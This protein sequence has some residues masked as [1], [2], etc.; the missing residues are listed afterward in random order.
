MQNNL[1]EIEAVGHQAIGNVRFITGEYES[2]ISNYSKSLAAAKK[3]NDRKLIVVALNNLSNSYDRKYQQLIS[4]A[5]SAEELG[6]T[7]AN[8][9]EQSSSMAVKARNY[10]I[11]AVKESRF[12][13]SLFSVEAILQLVKLAKVYSEKGIVEPTLVDDHLR[14]A[15][16]I[17]SNL[18]SSQRKARALIDMARLE[19]DSVSTLNYALEVAESIGDLPTQSMALGYLGA[20]YERIRDYDKALQ[21]THRAQQVAG[22]IRAADLLYRWDWQAGRIYR[23]LGRDKDAVRAYQQ[24]IASLQLIRSDLATKSEELQI[25]FQ[26]EVEPVYRQLIE[27]LLA[28]NHSER[29]IRQALE[30]KDLLQLSELENYFG[31]DCIIVRADETEVSSS[32]TERDKTTVVNTIILEQN[33]YLILQLPNGGVKSFTLPVSARQ[34]NQMVEQW[35]YDLENQENESYLTLSRELYQLLFKTIKS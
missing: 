26:L 31:D 9:L 18:P 16:E 5:E 25:D 7:E 30:V 10:A 27:L 35:R 32:D 33:T 4:Q 3:L 11:D 22:Q 8:L 34:M 6:Q 23:A 24:A 13:Q 19:E 28:G 2:A 1:A 14:R 15:N 21:L 20:Y 29:E 17:L 12:S